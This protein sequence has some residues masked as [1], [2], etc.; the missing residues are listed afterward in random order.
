MLKGTRMILKRGVQVRHCRVTGI[1][2]LR[3]QAEVREAKFFDQP[4]PH[5][6]L[7][8]PGRLAAVCMQRQENTQ[9]EITGCG[10]Q[11]Y[12]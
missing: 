3:K 6:A 8:L 9:D 7:R 4:G 11:K 1:A 5:K 12:C 10:Q 2:G